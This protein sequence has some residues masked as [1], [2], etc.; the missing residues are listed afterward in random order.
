VVFAGWSTLQAGGGV[1]SPATRGYTISSGVTATFD[2]NGNTMSVAGVI[3]GAGSLDK[4]GLGALSLGG[5]D[6]FSGNTRILAGVLQTANSAALQFSTLDMNAADS[7]SLD[8]GGNANVVLGGLQGSRDLAI[9]PFATLT[10]GN[11]NSSTAYSGGMN[12]DGSALVKVGNGSL[13]LTGSN[14]Y[15]G[16][17]TIADGRLQLG[18]GIANNGYVAGNIT[19]NAMLVFA[20]PAAQTFSGVISGRGIL[21]KGGLGTLTL[22]N[23][24][25]YTGDTVI[26]SG[27][28]VLASAGAIPGGAGAG[29][30]TVNGTLDLNGLSPTLNGLS[31]QPAGRVTNTAG[32]AV[33]LTVESERYNTINGTVDNGAGTL[34]LIKT[35]SGNL[36]VN[37]NL[38]YTGRTLIHQGTLTLTAASLASSVN[39]AAGA[40]LNVADAGLAG[41]YY[42]I[43]PWNYN[44][45]NPNF[46]SLATL[47]AHLAG[48]IPALRVPSASAG[49]NFDFG[50]NG[51]GFP[52]IGNSNFEAYYSGYFYAPTQG[53]YTFDTGSDDGSMIFINGQ[54]VVNNNSFQSI[55]VRS[56]T[57]SLAAGP[58]PIVIGYYQGSG[59]YGLYADVTL[60]GGSSQRLPNSLLSGGTT[61]GSLTGDAGSTVQLSSG[62][63]TVNQTGDGTF[64]GSITGSGALCKS[65][66]SNLTLLGANTFSGGAIINAGGLTV[67][68]SLACPVTVNAGASLGPDTP[69]LGTLSVSALTL[70]PGGALDFQ[71]TAGSNNQFAVSTSG[72]LTIN[73]GGINLYQQGTSIPFTTNGIYDLIQ[74]QGILGGS[75]LNLSVLNGELDKRYVLGTVGNEVVLNIASGPVW[76]GGSLTDTKWSDAANWIGVA[77]VAGDSLT[78]DGNRGTLNNNDLPAGM[79]FNSLWFRPR[80]GAFVLSG[81]SLALSGAI[82]NSSS[83]LQA[84]ALPITLDGTG[85]TI[86]ATGGPLTL[87]GS[88]DNGGTLLTVAGGN[89]VTLSGPISGN[90]GLT[91]VNTAVLLLTNSNNSYGGS[92]T[93]SAGTTCVGADSS[94]GSPTALLAFNGGALQAEAAINSSRPIS[95]LGG[96]ATID[97]QSFIVTLNGPISGNSPLTKLGTGVLALTCS[98]SIGGPLTVSAG[99]LQ[100]GNP[101]ALGSG[102]LTLGAATLDLY[103]TS[104]NPLSSLNGAAGS[105]ITD[106]ATTAGTSVLSVNLPA[107]E[108]STFSG[109]IQRGPARDIALNT[110]GPGTLILSGSDSYTG[111]TTVNAGTLI[112]T[113][114]TAIPDGT[115]LT[116]GAGGTV[117]FD[118][119]V[120]GT[121]VVG[122]AASSVAAVPEPGT[123]VLLTA[124]AALLALYRK[125]G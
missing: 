62:W 50:S 58:N 38:T 64:A 11:N 125:K 9:A 111:G 28:V 51:A 45:Y 26:S 74:Y 104:L 93:L 56:G 105:V 20:N 4:A 75:V 35:G 31:S 124:G 15:S 33:A 32:G 18:D 14:T 114:N 24:N 102:N 8:M 53:V 16:G 57:V 80:A 48:Q 25:T 63:L 47:N 88:L 112:L 119:S 60:P 34:S 89:N 76:N 13:V 46:T 72:G 55:T 82:I 36:T 69:N 97:T 30:V 40:T 27:I 54:T 98:N 83:N 37:N 95:L 96:G 109:S 116:V 10:V 42:N 68:G 122:S 101:A 12:G 117:I 100:V 21:F 77:P 29:N 81:N 121:P 79:Q 43:A 3:G 85:C 106:S 44:G 113:S 110:N 118:P 67:S 65:G 2:T 6:T 87:S 5:A 17:T 92:T 90:G 99:T 22:A 41:Q 1:A 73:G 84:I 120:A 59:S 23:T 49:V 19:N 52:P 94:F 70:N 123:L 91:M 86:Q 78:F 7:G 108:V 115:S 61:I 103:G 39:V 71:L 66:S 107:G